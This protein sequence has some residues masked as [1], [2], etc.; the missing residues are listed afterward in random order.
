MKRNY[1]SPVTTAQIIQNTHFLCSSG[2]GGGRS[3][4]SNVGLT[5]GNNSGDVTTAF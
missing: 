2:S 1:I 4:N 3:I 5:G